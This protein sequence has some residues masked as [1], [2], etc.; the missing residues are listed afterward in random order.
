MQEEA[1]LLNEMVLKHEETALSMRTAWE[2]VAL[3]WGSNREMMWTAMK[4]IV[5]VAQQG[6]TN[7][8]MSFFDNSKKIKDVLKDLG[9]SMLSILVSYFVKMLLQRMIFRK[10][11]EKQQL[12]ESTAQVARND[13]LGR[14][15]A[16]SR[17]MESPGGPLQAVAWGLSLMAATTS[18]NTSIISE[19][20]GAAVTGAFNGT[21]LDG[22][23]GMYTGRDSV[24]AMVSPGELI[25]N[26]KDSNMIR[27]IAATGGT[28]GGDTYNIT[29][30][31]ADGP[32]VAEWFKNQFVKTIRESA[33]AK[34]A[35]RSSMR[36]QGA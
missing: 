33:E 32:S 29:I 4:D 25:F 2:A 15:A 21:G 3:S 24:P 35:T 10:L 17:G 5:S 30:N 27:E 20:S 9:K 31:A 7:L 1:V 11:E 36:K 28:S 12:K 16:W 14:S 13:A 22:V 8:F 6:M 26:N 18:L 34:R 19:L 23:P